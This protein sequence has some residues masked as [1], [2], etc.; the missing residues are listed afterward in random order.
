MDGTPQHVQY[1]PSPPKEVPEMTCVSRASHGVAVLGARSSI[2][3]ATFSSPLQVLSSQS[4][5]VEMACAMLLSAFDSHKCGW[6]GFGGFGAC[7]GGQAPLPDA[8]A[9]E[10]PSLAL[11]DEFD[12]AHVSF[13]KDITIDLGFSSDLYGSAGSLERG[14]SFAD[15][16]AES[17][18]PAEHALEDDGPYG[19]A[20]TSSF[21][22][23]L[24]PVAVADPSS[25]STAIAKHDLP[26]PDLRELRYLPVCLVSTNFN[27]YFH[28]LKTDATNSNVWQNRK[29]KGCK[30][31]SRYFHFDKLVEE[32][33]GQFRQGWFNRCSIRQTKFCDVAP[34]CGGSGLDSLAMLHKAMKSIGCP[35]WREVKDSLAAAAAHDD[36]CEYFDQEGMQGHACIVCA[37]ALWKYVRKRDEKILVMVGL[38]VC[39]ACSVHASFRYSLVCMPHV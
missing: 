25:T 23:A 33:E 37:S 16:N 13:G 27:V 8:P 15:H 4:E 7:P 34:V 30:V 35:T 38:A 1:F 17:L 6:F 5:M 36:R 9:P 10:L 24:V 12:T 20:G 22:D 18:V 11:S 31:T 3:L 28:C 32:I 26:S 21:P 2:I 29:L 39:L 14:D 19:P